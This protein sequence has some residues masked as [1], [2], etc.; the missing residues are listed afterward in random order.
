M[1]WTTGGLTSFDLTYCHPQ[2]HSDHKKKHGHGQKSDH[3]DHDSEYGGK[4]AKDWE[5]DGKVRSK[6]RVRCV[7]R[8]GLRANAPGH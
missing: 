8:G 1:G 6:P 2:G 4:W 7:D 5:K 3:G